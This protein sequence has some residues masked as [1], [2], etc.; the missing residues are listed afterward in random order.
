M[1]EFEKSHKLPLA[2]KAKEIYQLVDGLTSSISEDENNL[3]LSQ[4]Q[5]MMEDALLILTK[6]SGAEAGD[7][8]DI[9]MEN[10]TIIRKCARELYVQAGSLDLYGFERSEYAKLI[11]KEIEEFK[12]LFREWVASFDP[13]N[14]IVDDW[15]LFNPPGISPNEE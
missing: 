3:L 14:Y 2:Q 7:L 9:R 13:W 10:A 11:R 5:F 8:Y 15:G 4:R 12:I 1:N 6:I